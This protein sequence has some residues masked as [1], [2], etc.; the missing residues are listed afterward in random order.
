MNK[1][2]LRTFIESHIENLS[3]RNIHNLFYDAIIKDMFDDCLVLFDEI[4]QPIPEIKNLPYSVKFDATLMPEYLRIEHFTIWLKKFNELLCKFKLPEFDF[5]KSA[6][7]KHSGKR[8]FC[9]NLIRRKK[10]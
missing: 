2:K 10:I 9:Y 6:N 8:S 4:S 3:D 5:T 1:S 7:G